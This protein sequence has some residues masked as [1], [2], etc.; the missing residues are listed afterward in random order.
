MAYKKITMNVKERI[1]VLC[2]ILYNFLPLTARG[3]STVTFKSIF[4]DSKIEKYLEGPDN[5]KQALQQGWEKVIRYNPRLPKKLIRKIVPAAIEYR[6]VKRN[7]IKQKEIDD[8]I[9]VL[10]DLGFDMSGE[11]RSIVI[12]ESMPEIQVPP[13]ELFKRLENHPLDE[14]IVSEP[15]ELFRNG[16]YNESVRKACEKFEVFVQAKSGETEIGK[17]LMGKVFN[18]SSPLIQLNALSTDNEEGIQ[19]GYMHLTIGLMR[20]IR[21]VFS[22]GDEAARSPEEAFEMLLFINWLF[23][24]I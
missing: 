12:D 2:D 16:H 24:F 11:L 20:G 9:I 17:S 3:K 14:N 6:R 18:I 13:V 19:E 1:N 15:L 4:K 8:L 10:N 22:H 7:P 23:R 21:N 5:K